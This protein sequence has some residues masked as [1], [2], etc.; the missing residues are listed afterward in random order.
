MFIVE[1]RSRLY[2]FSVALVLHR[3]RLRAPC[4]PSTPSI[5]LSCWRWHNCPTTREASYRKCPHIRILVFRRPRPSAHHASHLFRIP[6]DFPRRITISACPSFSLDFRQRLTALP[7]VPQ[8][9]RYTVQKPFV[10]P[11]CS[12]TRRLTKAARRFARTPVPRLF[13]R[14]PPTTPRHLKSINRIRVLLS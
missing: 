13:L 9:R 8:D 2:R 11:R 4:N 5:A 7:L 14:V 3:Y 12:W 6:L 1:Q 10:K